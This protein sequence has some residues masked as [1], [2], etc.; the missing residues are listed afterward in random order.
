MFIL[1][2]VKISKPA[3]NFFLY[4]PSLCSFFVFLGISFKFTGLALLPFILLPLFL[5]NPLEILG[6]ILCFLLGYIRV[7]ERVIPKGG[8]FCE[9]QVYD[10]G[11]GFV[12]G[13]GF[14]TVLFGDKLAYPIGNILVK[15]R[16]SNDT[17]YVSEYYKFSSFRPFVDL[18]DKLLIKS[19]GSESQYLFAKSII[20]GIREMDYKTKSMFYDTSVGHILAISGLH[21]GIIF[22]AVLYILRFL[23]LGVWS[24]VFSSLFVWVYAFFVGLIPSVF[25]ASLMLT[26]YTASK[27]ISRPVKSLNVFMLAFALCLLWEPLWIFSPSFWLSFS[28]ILGFILFPK[29]IIT[30]VF[31]ALIFS[32]PFS[33]YFFGK[34]PIIYAPLNLLIIPIMTLFMYSQ[35]LGMFFGYPFDKS[36]E[37]LF[38]ILYG[39]VEF[40]YNLHLPIL[41]FKI[42]LWMVILYSVFILSVVFLWNYNRFKG[43]V[44]ETG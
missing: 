1:R 18:V 11:K 21:V 42:P 39:L 9:V 15:G 12:V 31:G 8:D 4:Y 38:N 26:L 23:R 22:L 41:E 5:R 3:Y 20:T 24:Y 36:A 10:V 14:K 29:N 2:Q 34:S 30:S 13:E 43:Y 28:A 25:R 7:W 37:V 16:V 40:A 44:K 19:T 27:V 6:I 33:L 32:T 17:F 35:I